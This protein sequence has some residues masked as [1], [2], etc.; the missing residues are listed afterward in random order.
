MDIFDQLVEA[1]IAELNGGA[2]RGVG[3]F[4]PGEDPRL[5]TV[6]QQRQQMAKAADKAGKGIGWM[7]TALVLMAIVMGV[8]RARR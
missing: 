3:A 4:L 2:Q 6:S 5:P 7:V 8:S 1:E